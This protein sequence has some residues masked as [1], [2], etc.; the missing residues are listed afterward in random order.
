MG[1][2]LIGM[3]EKLA[4]H[5]ER[6]DS[7]GHEVMAPIAQDTDDLRC[8]GVIEERE[9]RLDFSLV[10]RGHGA[11]LHSLSGACPESLHISQTDG[12]LDDSFLAGGPRC[13]CF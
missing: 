7:G 2:L 11:V 5:A 10:P 13:C 8:E 4:L 12:L 9:H 1:L 3:F 6:T